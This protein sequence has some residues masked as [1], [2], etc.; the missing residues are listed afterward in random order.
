M[1]ET[2]HHRNRSPRSESDS[3]DELDFDRIGFEEFK[4]EWAASLRRMPS[5]GDS[6]AADAAKS[7]SKRSAKDD[8]HFSIASTKAIRKRANR[9]TQLAA[10]KLDEAIAQSKLRKERKQHRGNVKMEVNK[11]K[12]RLKRYGF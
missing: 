5:D 1:G 9:S 10:L 6:D 2:N 3:E 7:K 11:L 4:R 8:S 12:E